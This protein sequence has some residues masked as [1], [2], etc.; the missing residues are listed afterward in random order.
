MRR[1][2]RS[3]SLAITHNHA[4]LTAM[5][6]RLALA[7]GLVLAFVAAPAAAQIIPT[8]PALENRI[9]APLPPPPPP[10][11][12]GPLGQSP[13]PG[14]YIPPRLN[15]QSD[16]VIGCQHQGRGDGLRG[17]QLQ[18]YIRECANAN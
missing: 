8:P 15:T 7:V 14:V 16:R 13:P 18:A 12:N 3:A 4:Y 5:H 9:P 6:G 1:L 2:N 10:I 17:R 11:I